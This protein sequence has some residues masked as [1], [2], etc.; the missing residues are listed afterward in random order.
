M[1]AAIRD[2]LTANPNLKGREVVDELKKQYPN[3][4]INSNSAHVAFSTARRTLGISGGAKKSVRRRKPGK[5]AA[6]RPTAAAGTA[7]VNLAHLKAARKFVAEIGNVRDA[8][9]AVQQLEALQIE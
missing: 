1:S 9:V 3:E 5:G 6:R 8:V 7:T 4:R 2:L